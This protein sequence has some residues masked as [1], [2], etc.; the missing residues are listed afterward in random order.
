MFTWTWEKLTFILHF[1]VQN[2]GN[3]K[4]SEILA[5]QGLFSRPPLSMKRM[6][7]SQMV[8]KACTHKHSLSWHEC[9][10]LVEPEHHCCTSSVCLHGQTQRHISP[11]LFLTPRLPGFLIGRRLNSHALELLQLD[12]ALSRLGPH[13]LSDSEIRQVSQSERFTGW[14]W[15]VWWTLRLPRLGVL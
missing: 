5:V 11:L 2:G 10:R 14:T 13:Q 15:C 7:V 3:P 8:S 9:R 4:V 12:R 1:Q 6:S